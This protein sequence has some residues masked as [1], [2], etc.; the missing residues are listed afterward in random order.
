MA[1]V[2]AQR[3]HDA[4]TKVGAVL[5]DPAYGT[6]IASG[7]NGFIRNTCDDKLPSNRPDKYSYM[8]HAEMNLICNAARY[9]HKTDGGI[10]YCTM[11]PCVSCVRALWQAGIVYVYFKDKYKDF[12]VSTSMLDLNMNVETVD[13]LFFMTLSVK[14]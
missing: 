4:E 3:S 13:D 6:L 10:L 12:N 14:S 9:G 8:V 5:V 2:V 7:F 1:E 11:S